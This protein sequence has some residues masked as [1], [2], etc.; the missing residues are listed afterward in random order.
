MALN[1]LIPMPLWCQM[2][3]NRKTGNAK[4]SGFKKENGLQ[5]II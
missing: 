2:M 5:I 4:K 1:G 3:T